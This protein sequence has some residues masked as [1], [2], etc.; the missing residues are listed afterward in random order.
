MGHSFFQGFFQGSNHS[1]S[2]SFPLPPAMG[3]NQSAVS[4]LV[5]FSGEAPPKGTQGTTG[6][7]GRVW[8]ELL[9]T[10]WVS[11]LVLGIGPTPPTRMVV[12]LLVSL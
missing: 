9:E 5:A 10:M 2:C 4:L 8:Y 1:Y 6:G 7:L 3:N 12:F 11:R